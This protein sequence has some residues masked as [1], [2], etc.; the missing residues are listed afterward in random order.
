MPFIAVSQSA[1]IPAT[2]IVY[3]PAWWKIAIL[4]AVLLELTG[5]S[6]FIKKKWL[7]NQEALPVKVAL[8]LMFMVFSIYFL[9]GTV[10][11][12]GSPKDERAPLLMWLILF[13][14]PVSV[15]YSLTLVN[16]LS[17]R[18]V[19]RLTPVGTKIPEAPAIIQ[20]RLLLQAGKITEAQDVLT[21][22]FQDRSRALEFTA[23]WFREEGNYEKAA[24]LLE[25]LIE[26]PVKDPDFWSE[27]AY[28]LGKLYESFL[29]QPLKTMS[30]FQRIA[31]ECP[32]SR[33]CSLAEA[34]LARLRLIYSDQGESDTV[35]VPAV[36][37]SDSE[38]W[39]RRRVLLRRQMPPAS[40]AADQ[41]K[42]A[43]TD[44]R[45]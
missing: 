28:S 27:A 1:E 38:F 35:A 42:E 25:E 31:A 10:L 20:T 13:I 17:W 30:L 22:L 21:E 11:Y 16:A 18:G 34:D 15:Q 2:A 32:G 24:S 33:F 4:I 6:F 5:I 7:E 12:W 44:I 3:L 36:P 43:P 29:N 14:I 23:H 26:L 37:G 39:E 40:S 41:P 19:Q 9:V 8:T 45:Q